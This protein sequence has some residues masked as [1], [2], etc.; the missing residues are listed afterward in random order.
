[1]NI[2]QISLRRPVLAIVLNLVIVLFGIIGFKFLGVRDYPAIDPPNISVSTSYSGANSDIKPGNSLPLTNIP[3]GTIIHNI[4]VKKDC[5]A[6][7]V[8]TAG[9]GAQLMAKEGEFANVRLPSGEMRLIH[10]NCMATIGQVGNVEHENVSIGKAGRSRWLGKRPANRGVVMNPIDH[11]HGGCEGRSPIGRAPVT[12]WG[13]PALG[14]RTRKHK[15][16]DRLIVKR[17]A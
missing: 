9:A 6:K 10:V 4:E 15:A 16:S 7:L 2:S 3:V 8:R 12:P 14:H 1:M 11:P 5:G 13:K 17:R